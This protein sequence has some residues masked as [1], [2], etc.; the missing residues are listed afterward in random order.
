MKKGILFI[1]TVM[2]TLVGSL[3]AQ[4]MTATNGGYDKKIKIDGKKYRVMYYEYEIDESVDNVWAEVSGNFMNVAD[5]VG[6][7][8]ESSC[9]SGDVT[10]G[11]GA[12]R[13]C[14]LD[15]QGKTLKIKEEIIDVKETDNRKEF[16][17][18]VYEAKGF[19]A[20]VFNTWVVRK[21]EDGKTYLGTAFIFRPKFPFMG[22][23]M[24]R[25]LKKSGGVRTGVLAY[26]HF[27]EE[28]QSQADSEALA[29]LYPDP[30][31]W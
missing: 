20:K 11:L 30:Q 17:Y 24:A 2:V 25:K 5:I 29:K 18:D 6:S 21:G 4:N 16:T 28:G 7:V 3:S 8:T 23:M 22:R 31:G 15:F 13:Y 9:E 12:K 1:L 26:K 27:F 19:P 14:E 10:S